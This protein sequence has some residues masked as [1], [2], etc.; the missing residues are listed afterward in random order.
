MSDI[1]KN[2]QEMGNT[3]IIY[4]TTD[5]NIAC[6]YCYQ[7]EDRAKNPIM[8]ASKKQIDEF[9][10][11]LIKTEPGF[12]STVVVFGGEPFLEADNI[13]YMYE[14]AEQITKKTGKTYS[15]CTDTNGIWFS[16]ESNLQRFL[17]TVQ[18]MENNVSLEVSYDG[19]S[20][21]RRVDKAGKSTSKIVK[22]V[23][24]RLKEEN[25][26]FHLRYTVHKESIKTFKTDM[27]KLSKFMS[28]HPD[29]RIVISLFD[30]E[31]E[32]VTGKLTKYYTQEMYPFMKAIFYKYK[33]P[34]CEYVC[35]DCN[36][37]SFNKDKVNKYTI[38]G[39]DESIKFEVKDAG[40]F[41]H[42]SKIKKDPNG[43]K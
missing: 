29:N 34:L 15:F 31:I 16:K 7:K 20:N 6:D 24:N 10:E 33:V 5:C 37:C 40:D 19:D 18:K 35:H 17:N 9:L 39:Y 32:E 41:D 30:N 3:N 25:F 43:N 26:K 1:S 4:M 28:Y 38:P 27:L 21:Q 22:K 8:K 14:K 36:L 12:T 2:T 13:F 42:F 23:L 11:N